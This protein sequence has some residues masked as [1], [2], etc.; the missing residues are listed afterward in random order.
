MKDNRTLN[1][2][3]ENFGAEPITEAIEMFDVIPNRLAQRTKA[4]KAGLAYFISKVTAPWKVTK[5]KIPSVM[6]QGCTFDL[7][8]GQVVFKGTL[9]FNAPKNTEPLQARAMLT[10]K[11]DQVY[12]Q[13]YPAGSEMTLKAAI[14]DLIEKVKNQ[15][16]RP[17]YQG[18]FK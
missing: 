15:A 13:S 11:K 9:N 5:S 8:D 1:E 17:E 10:N 12:Y 18:I 3:A 7:T 6:T 2:V 14:N 16:S 4:F